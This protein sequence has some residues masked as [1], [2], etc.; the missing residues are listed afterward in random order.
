MMTRMARL[1]IA[2]LA[3]TLACGDDSPTDPNGGGG[4]LTADVSGTAFSAT[5]VVA[6]MVDDYLVIT[7]TQSVGGSNTRSI[8]INVANVDGED[9][10]DLTAFGNSGTYAELNNSIASSW[11]TAVTQGSGSINITSITSTTIA[12][13]FSFIAPANTI[14]PATGTKT[15]TSGTFNVTLS[16]AS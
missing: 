9:S 6:N 3:F 2:T 12:G 10:Y 16:T 5:V 8:T 13:T 14:S 11:L 15:V 7:A 1:L 4:T